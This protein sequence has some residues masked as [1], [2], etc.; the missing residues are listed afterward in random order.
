[1][2]FPDKDSLS[3]YGGAMSNYAIGV[4]DPTTEEDASYRNKYVASVA[5]MTRMCPLAMRSFVGTTN[6]ATSISDPTTGFVHDAAWG[7]D[8]SDKPSCT[9]IAT[10]TTDVIWPTTVQDELAED[11]T[12]SFNRA[13]ADVESSDGVLRLATAKVTGANKVRVYTYTRATAAQPPTLSNLPGEVITV[14]VR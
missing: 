5:G 4:V 10:G 14:Y 13:W 6:G 3:T 9:F 8:P 1:M 12:V 7:N 2:T 11:H